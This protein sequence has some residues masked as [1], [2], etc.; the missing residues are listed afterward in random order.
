MKR[1]RGLAILALQEK[2]M[3]TLEPMSFLVIWPLAWVLMINMI[4][5][6]FLAF[7]A[8]EECTSVASNGRGKNIRKGVRLGN[9]GTESE[10]KENVL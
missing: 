9:S 5:S 6:L 2:V 4:N 10:G 3:R 1:E 7:A 8:Q